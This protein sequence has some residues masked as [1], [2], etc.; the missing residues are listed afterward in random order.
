MFMFR[1]PAKTG[2]TEITC[3]APCTA[4]LPTKILDFRGFESSIISISRGGIIMSTGDFPESL[5]QAILVGIV[6]VGRLGVHRTCHMDITYDHVYIQDMATLI[7]KS[8]SEAALP[9]A[10]ASKVAYSLLLRILSDAGWE[11][12]I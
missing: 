11:D 8:V 7:T 5:S 10:K 4:N 6:L 3:C 12:I 1:L 9:H 2:I